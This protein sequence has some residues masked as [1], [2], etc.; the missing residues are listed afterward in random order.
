VADGSIT[1]AGKAASLSA[2]DDYENFVYR[3]EA[4]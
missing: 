3:M 4:K 2:R 1:A